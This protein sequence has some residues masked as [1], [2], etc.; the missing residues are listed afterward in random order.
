MNSINLSQSN[1]YKENHSSSK[2]F[3]NKDILNPTNI[4]LGANVGAHIVKETS[5]VRDYGFNFSKVTKGEY[6]R[7]L[8]SNF[9]HLDNL[10]L[11]INMLSLM[12]ISPHFFRK[13]SVSDFAGVSVCTVMSNLA[14]EFF[15]ANA[16]AFTTKDLGISFGS[17]FVA[18]QNRTFSVGF[19]SILC[20]MKGA[21]AAN[22]CKKLDAPRALIITELL[23]TVISGLIFEAFSGANVSHISHISGLVAGFAYGYFFQ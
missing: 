5:W 9:I 12:K 10:H 19:S 3:L 15:L 16:V 7:I 4:L 18:N 23:T 13:Y 6:H 14:T 20:G 17:N 22:E 8:T 1:S 11:C 2:P 21:L